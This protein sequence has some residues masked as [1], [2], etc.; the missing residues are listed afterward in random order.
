MR[1]GLGPPH[2][3][4][5]ELRRTQVWVTWRAGISGGLGI[6][7]RHEGDLMVPPCVTHGL[8]PGSSVQPDS[9]N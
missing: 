2:R 1:T 6:G 4:S 9:V 8:E 3:G 7:F 5:P